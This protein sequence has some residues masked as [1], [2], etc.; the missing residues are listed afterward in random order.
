[1]EGEDKTHTM[2]LLYFK[3]KRGGETA[4]ESYYAPVTPSL[5]PYSQEPLWNNASAQLLLSATSRSFQGTYQ[6]PENPSMILDMVRWIKRDYAGDM[7]SLCTYKVAMP[8][9]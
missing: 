2:G 1:M 9:P 3:S 8:D 5:I 4:D 7:T 6:L